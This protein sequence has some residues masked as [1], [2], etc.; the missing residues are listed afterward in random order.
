MGPKKG[1]GVCARF[2]GM[3]HPH[4][5]ARVLKYDAPVVG[6]KLG[7]LAVDKSEERV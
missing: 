2:L 6:K 4:L 7:Q 3:L 5:M 1:F